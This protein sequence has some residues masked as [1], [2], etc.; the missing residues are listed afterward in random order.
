MWQNN[1]IEVREQQ[2]VWESRLFNVAAQGLIEGVTGLLLCGKPCEG[3][4]PLAM[5]G[6]RGS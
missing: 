2:R 3:H 6:H 1:F 5:G 4:W